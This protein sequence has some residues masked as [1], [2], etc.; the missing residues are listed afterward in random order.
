MGG[1]RWL[2]KDTDY[3]TAFWCAGGSGILREEVWANER[4]EVV[5]YNLAFLLPHLF[6]RD[7]GRVLGFDNAHGT[8]ERHFMGN[9]ETVEFTSYQETA[10]RF[11]R[12]VS[13]IRRSNE[14]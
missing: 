9:V 13:E 10:E 12:E 2:H 5:R 6:Y 3:E 1:A 11:Y 8:H 14:G 4:D 7:N